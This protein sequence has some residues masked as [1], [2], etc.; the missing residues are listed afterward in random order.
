MAKKKKCLLIE[1]S[2]FPSIPQQQFSPV[3]LLNLS[4]FKGM[5]LYLVGFQDGFDNLRDPFLILIT[6]LFTL[7]FLVSNSINKLIT[8]TLTN[9]FH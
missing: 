9:L 1:A 6:I 2:F 7:Y 8:I 4:L 3:Y 5:N